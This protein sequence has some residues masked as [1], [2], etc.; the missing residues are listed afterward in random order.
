MLSKIQSLADTFAESVINIILNTPLGELDLQDTKTPRPP[1]LHPDVIKA[2]DLVE[3]ESKVEWPKRRK[4]VRKKLANK[5]TKVKSPPLA[6]I[7]VE[8]EE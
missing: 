8:L 2:E 6:L 4:V 5:T 3:A 7:H 1:R